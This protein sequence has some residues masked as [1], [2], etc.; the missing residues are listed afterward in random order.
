MQVAAPTHLFMGK[1]TERHGYYNQVSNILEMERR[2]GAPLA[3]LHNS[4][5]QQPNAGHFMHQNSL[6][7]NQAMGQ[8]KQNQTPRCRFN[9]YE[10]QSTLHNEILLFKQ[11]ANA[12]MKEMQQVKEILI[13]RITNLVSTVLPSYF[14]QIYGS[15]ATGLCL[16]WSDIDMVVGSKQ[17]DQDQLS[18]MH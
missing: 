13:Q 17:P 4:N 3:M 8:Q 14:V 9:F 11:D 12:M 10:I 2:Y 1:H 18:S 15:H 7:M 5:A 16:H 6:A